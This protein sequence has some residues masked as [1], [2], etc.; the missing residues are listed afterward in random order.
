MTGDRDVRVT[1]MSYADDLCLTAN[2][3]DQ[4][5]IMLDKLSG[6]AQRKGLLVNAAKSEV[7]HFNSMG[8]NVP[9]FKLGGFV[10]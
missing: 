8:D 3:P 6:Y 9:V 7:V 2:A 10:G 1:H 4:L 5:Q